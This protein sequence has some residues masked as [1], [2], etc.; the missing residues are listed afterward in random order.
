MTSLP[1]REA[2]MMQQT[3]LKQRQD[4]V[5][6]MLARA[7]ALMEKKEAEAGMQDLRRALAEMVEEKTRLE[8]E[9]KSVE[10]ALTKHVYVI[11]GNPPSSTTGWK[12]GVGQTRPLVVYDTREQA[13]AKLPKPQGMM[14]SSYYIEEVAMNPATPPWRQ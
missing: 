13:E 14:E 7:Q 2:L 5:E 12:P 10:Q 4:E 3:R 11:M 9:L 8:S 1:S 6:G